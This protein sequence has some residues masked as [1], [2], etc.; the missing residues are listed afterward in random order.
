MHTYWPEGMPTSLHYP[1]LPV[2]GLLTAAARLYGD[3][4]AVVDGDLRL[5]FAEVRELAVAFAHGLRGTGV[6]DGDVVLL[7][8]SNSAWFLIGY[9]GTLLAGATVS[10]ANPLQPAPGLHAQLLDTGAVAAVSH[11]AHLTPLTEARTGSRLRT[12]VVV[13]PSACAPSAVPPSAAPGVIALADLLTGHTDVPPHTAVTGDDVAQILYT[14]GTTGVSKGVRVLHRNVVANVTQ[15]TAWRAAHLI[16]EEGGG[17]LRLRPLPGPRD[18][19]MRPGAGVTVLQ[20]P[21]F[22]VHA[23]INTIFL[24][25]CGTTVVLSGRFSPER[26][27]A[28]IEEHRAT[29]LLGSPTMWQALLAGPGVGEHDLS[30]VRVISSGGAPID[31]ATLTSLEA[32][33]PAAAVGEGY[34]LTE[35]TCLV[36]STP[37]LHGARRKLGSVGL[38]L[39][40]T[41]VE[42]RPL[43]GG[44]AALGPN[45]VGELWVR[46]PQVTAGY[47][48]RPE[49]GAEQFVAGWLRTGDLGY[50]DEDGFVFLSGRAKEMLIYKGYNVYPRELEDILHG[51]PGLRAAAVIGRAHAPVGQEPVAFVVP[52]PGADVD[53]EEVMAYVAARVLPY[54][55]I[56]AVHIVDSL[57]LSAAGKILKSRL[58]ALPAADDRG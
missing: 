12:V 8:L 27:L 6:R 30:S 37:L 4:V 25:L 29:Y 28:S 52:R 23:L 15:M 57:P 32:A 21:L 58:S 48:N 47:L 9:Y 36:T 53:P 55:K 33:F 56:R 19:G 45:E 13:P 7:H 3:R 14:G 16:T 43:T 11:P 20:S 10:P 35:G 54:K 34:G 38:P 1:D 17:D 49:A 46:G 5:S 39:F 41:T 51:H 44:S 31:K 18:P 26:M 22:H 24:L 2:C 40:D 50:V 42:I